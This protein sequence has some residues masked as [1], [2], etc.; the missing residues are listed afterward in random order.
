VV[1]ID[2]KKHVK[3]LAKIIGSH[4]YTCTR[5]LSRSQITSQSR[6]TQSSRTRTQT[7]SPPCTSTRSNF[8]TTFCDTFST[9]AS[10]F[11]DHSLD[12]PFPRS[13]ALTR[14]QS[15]TSSPDHVTAAYDSFQRELDLLFHEVETAW[16][17]NQNEH[18]ATGRGY[19]M[20]ISSGLDPFFVPSRSSTPLSPHALPNCTHQ[21]SPDATH[22]PVAPAPEVISSGRSFEPLRAVKPPARARLAPRIQQAVDR[23]DGLATPVRHIQGKPLTKNRLKPDLGTILSKPTLVSSEDLSADTKRKSMFVQFG[24][25]NSSGRNPVE[26][27][28]VNVSM[29]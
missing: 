12:T 14:T 26:T 4:S 10:S 19:S 25:A 22:K 20:P 18:D 17:I 6:Y 8:E 28:E 16:A 15:R 13:P 1:D 5:K 7:F 9:F 2:R 21:A 29:K 24:R 11:V 23:F 27:G 3:E